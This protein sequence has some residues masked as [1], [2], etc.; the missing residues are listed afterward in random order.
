MRRTAPSPLAT[1]YVAPITTLELLADRAMAVRVE[2]E[3]IL[4]PLR[5]APR[6]GPGAG[7][8]EKLGVL[9]C[10]Q[11]IVDFAP[12]WSSSPGA[13]LLGQVERRTSFE[14]GRASCRER[15]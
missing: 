15:V 11:E 1:V 10:I 2:T 9:S 14:I 13:I 7:Q 4:H 6:A 12:G 5:V 8:V 3:F